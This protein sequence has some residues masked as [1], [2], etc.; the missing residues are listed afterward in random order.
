M[1]R[2]RSIEK[3]CVILLA[4]V[5]LTGAACGKSKSSKDNPV[6][7]NSS[8]APLKGKLPA[9]I[10]KAGEIK[11]GSDI[12]YPPVEFFKEGTQ[13]VQGIDVDIANA[14]GAKLGVKF[15]FINDTDFAG[16]IAALRSGR[17]DIIMSAMNDN[18]ERQ[19]KGVDF[20]DYYS[21]GTS[22]L[23]TKGNPDKISQLYDLCGKTVSVQKG[24]TQE[25][26]TLPPVSKKC[27]DTGK[28]AITILPFEKDTDALQQ[29]KIGRANAVVEDSPVAGYN[30]KTSG[31]GADFEVVGQTVDPGQYGIA[32]PKE[33][34]QLRDALREALKAIIADGTYDKILTTWGASSGALRSATINGQP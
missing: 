18:A 33:N 20:V 15:T 31:G 16:I 9:A 32:V 6:V 30:A 3:V 1:T 34:V 27:T 4:A 24:T 22:I 17:F 11:V 14:M 12:E 19:G 8:S 7:G 25:T 28:K 13:Q 23:V 21:A 10:A 29:V 2:G 5:L 26:D